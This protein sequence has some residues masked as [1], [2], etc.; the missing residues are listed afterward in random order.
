M[1]IESLSNAFEMRKTDDQEVRDS[2][3]ASC[4]KFSEFAREIGLNFGASPLESVGGVQLDRPEVLYQKAVERSH[5]PDATGNVEVATKD[6]EM[7]VILPDTPPG[8]P[9]LPPSAYSVMPDTVAPLLVPKSEPP[10]L[11]AHSRILIALRPQQIALTRQQ[12]LE[13]GLCGREKRLK[14]RLPDP[15]SRHRLLP[16][17]TRPSDRDTI[18]RRFRKTKMM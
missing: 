11:S 16:F 17:G 4:N 18:F 15:P 1:M 9:L 14:P 7:E 8:S 6:V 3:I 10:S 12:P 13:S 2:T 5:E